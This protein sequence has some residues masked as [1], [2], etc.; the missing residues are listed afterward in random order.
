MDYKELL[1]SKT[2]SVEEAVG[3][4]KDHDVIYTYGLSTEPR[5]FLRGLAALKGRV[6][7]V[8]VINSLNTEKFD[9]YTDPSYAGVL[10]NESLFYSRFC[11]EPTKLGL[12]SYVPAHLR[13]MGA[14]KI[15]YY[16]S[17]KK[18]IDIFVTCV[19]PLDKHGFFTSGVTGT[20]TRDMVENARM[21]ILEI[22]ENMPRTFGDTF[23]HINEADFVYQGENK[24]ACLEAREITDTDR[25]IGKYVADMV[26]DGST[27]QLGIGSIPDA[28][29]VELLN[30]HDLGVHTEML[31]DG[32]VKLFEAG[33]ITNKKKTYFPG[34]MV[35]S[36][37]YGNQKTYDFLNDNMGVLHLSI[38]R[39]NSP[40][41]IA[42]NDRMISINSTLEIDLMGQC[43]SEAVGPFQ[44]SGIGGQTDTAVGAKMSR[45]GK[46]IIVLHSTAMVKTKTGERER[47]SKVVCTHQGG[48]VISLLRADVDY[49]VTEYGVASLRGASLKER[50]LS[51]INIAH[52][53]F[54]SQLKE[55]AKRCS[56]L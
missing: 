7:D 18:P 16:D 15:Y 37:S 1:K 5:S 10:N 19:S 11:G 26:D 32:F 38:A 25:Q 31:G 55:E 43:A 56:L 17:R 3:K 12:L 39:A 36:F 14:D 8:T 4:V 33:V 30:K 51:L 2:V 50:A 21:I 48:T 53:D 23:I 42:K 34:K 6:K 52:P 35:T 54:R 24:L 44:L 47:I 41:E 9:Y 29:T 45:G 20:A 49:V 28:V 27:I 13:N 40:Y 22:N 46:S